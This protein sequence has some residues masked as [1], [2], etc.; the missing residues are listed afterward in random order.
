MESVLQEVYWQRGHNR[1]GSKGKKIFIWL[2]SIVL[3]FLLA[4]C[5]KS[6]VVFTTGLSSNE[7]FKIGSSV[8]TVP[9][10][11][12]YLTTAQNQYESVLGVDMWNRDFGGVT[13]EEYLKETILGQIAQIKSMELLAKEYKLKLTEDEEELVGTA[14]KHYFDSLNDAEIEYMD[15]SQDTIE[16]LY[17]E[18][19]LANKV[20]NEITKDVNPEVSDDEARNITVQHILF[21]TYEIDAEGNRE[22]MSEA[23]KKKQ[24][25]K[26]QAVWNEIQSGKDFLELA[27]QN[28]EDSQIEYVFG[29]GEMAKEFEET[30]FNLD[31]E[32][33][34]QIVT[35]EY[36]YHIIKCVSRFDRDET[37]A[38][39]AKILDKRKT[40]AFD[41]V[42]EEFIGQ[43][44]SQFNDKVWETITFLQN[45]EIKTMNFFD[46]Y[47]QF[48]S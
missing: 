5:G 6:S 7:V 27:E 2:S 41:K 14:S 10:A 32:E 33:I 45:D 22:E 4:S 40:E 28:S 39:K 34:S 8:C 19:A 15:I 29:K 30:A 16:N 18:Y 23:D 25:E 24:Y 12:I 36:G 44:P 37:D 35:T 46:V 11:K 17:R 13:L 21:K 43:L 42:Y 26:A 31:T 9:E 38:N 1:M 20:Y 48:L 47:N 3:I